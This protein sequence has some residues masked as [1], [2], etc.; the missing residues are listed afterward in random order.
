MTA[1]KKSKSKWPDALLACSVDTPVGELIVL[2]SEQAVTRILHRQ[3]SGEEALNAVPAPQGSVVA[4]AAQAILRWLRAETTRLD[5]PVQL[6]GTSFQQ[7]VW[8]AL[9]AIPHGTTVSYSELAQK[10]GQPTACRAVANACGQNPLPLIIPCH[11]VLHKSA[12]ISGF[13]WGKEIKSTLLALE[14]PLVSQRAA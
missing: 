1:P 12:R 2:G 4:E 11:R 3:W 10:I 6:H 7:R 13:A 8:S 9:T 5:F 14:A